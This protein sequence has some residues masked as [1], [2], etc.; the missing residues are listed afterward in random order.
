MR[1]PNLILC[2]IAGWSV[3]CL[4]AGLLITFC[5]ELCFNKLAAP[6]FSGTANHKE[7]NMKGRIILVVLLAVVFT[8][9][10]C[11]TFGNGRLD[12]PVDVSIEWQDN[13]GNGFTLV[14]GTVTEVHYASVKTGV[15]YEITD[16]GGFQIT[17]PDGTKVRIQRKETDTPTPTPPD[18]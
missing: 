12:L 9:A 7:I 18:Q 4:A 17:A 15:L 6:R 2:F 1:S 11:G 14:Q 8:L 5:E 3:L 13:F 10:G 16:S